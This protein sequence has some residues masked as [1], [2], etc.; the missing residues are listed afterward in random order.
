[1]RSVRIV[2]SPPPLECSGNRR[3]H[4]IAKSGAIKHYREYVS[5]VT[6]S[7]MRR[8]SPMTCATLT[9]VYGTAPVKLSDAPR[10]RPRDIDNA[11]ASI[12][13]AIDGLV[14][15]GAIVD[16]SFKHLT[17]ISLSID[18]RSPHLVLILQEVLE[19]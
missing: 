18:P 6:Q 19:R 12:K 4:T 14:S 10:Y 17:A 9:V 16:D 11:V 7:E 15:G 3:G 13:P 2:V 1:M 5:I 8:L